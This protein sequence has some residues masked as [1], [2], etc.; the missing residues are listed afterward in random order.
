MVQRRQRKYNKLIPGDIVRVKH[1]S[2]GAGDGGSVGRVYRCGKHPSFGLRIFV[3]FGMNYANGSPMT[4]A[5][6]PHQLEPASALERL[7]WEV[8]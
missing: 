1:E 6:S 2:R 7:A 5:F 3:W 4:L 8:E